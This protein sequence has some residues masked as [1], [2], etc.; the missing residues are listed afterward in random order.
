MEMEK[1]EIF[2]RMFFLGA[3]ALLLTAA[4]LMIFGFFCAVAFAQEQNAPEKPK[5]EEVTLKDNGWPFEVG[6][7]NFTF[8]K[9]D[10]VVAVNAQAQGVHVRMWRQNDDKTWRLLT[11]FHLTASD[12]QAELGNV[13]SP[14]QEGRLNAELLKNGTFQK[15]DIFWIQVES[16]P[17]KLKDWGQAWKN[18]LTEAV[19]GKKPE[20][21][22]KKKPALLG[23]VIVTLKE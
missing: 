18:G 14:K 13:L 11:K 4:I 9:P 21:K 3:G 17:E 15:G 19:S 10:K 6:N 20:E 2:A 23:N 16:T 8:T 5:E 1:R 7:V 12:T 22:D